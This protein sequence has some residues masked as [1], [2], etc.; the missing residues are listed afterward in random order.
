MN[1]RET[2]LRFLVRT[3]DFSLFQSTQIGSRAH[4]EGVAFTKEVGSNSDFVSYTLSI[5]ALICIVS[6]EIRVRNVL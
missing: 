4:G 5:Y 1:G 6:S 3:K 2:L